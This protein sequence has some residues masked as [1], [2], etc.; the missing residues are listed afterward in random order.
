MGRDALGDEFVGSGRQVTRTLP[1]PPLNNEHES[2]AAVLDLAEHDRALW[3]QTIG[4]G[5]LD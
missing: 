4:D 3:N 1:L 5:A 2:V